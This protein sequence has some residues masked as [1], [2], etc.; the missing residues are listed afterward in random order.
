MH[1]MHHQHAHLTRIFSRLILTWCLWADQKD[2]LQPLLSSATVCQVEALRTSA[3]KHRPLCP[4]PCRY[5]KF[6]SYAM[7]TPDLLTH[8]NINLVWELFPRHLKLALLISLKPSKAR[9]PFTIQG[10]SKSHRFQGHDLTDQGMP[11][12]LKTFEDIW[13]HQC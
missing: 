2:L 5:H 12:S 4:V 8:F 13:R 9:P 11:W 6:F 3:S 10:P 1:H 7:S